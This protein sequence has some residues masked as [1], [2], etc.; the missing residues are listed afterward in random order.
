MLGDVKIRG[1]KQMTG[2]SVDGLEEA[3]GGK[4]QS[5]CASDSSREARLVL[6]QG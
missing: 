4:L 3:L 2:L 6:L 5:G 1:E